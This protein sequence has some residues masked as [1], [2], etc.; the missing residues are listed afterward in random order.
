MLMCC[1]SLWN[2]LWK[3]SNVHLQLLVIEFLWVVQR[4]RTFCIDIHDSFHYA[5][6]FILLWILSSLNNNKQKR[7]HIYT[8]NCFRG[9]NMLLLVSSCFCMFIHTAHFFPN[10]F[11]VNNDEKMCTMVSIER[12][13]VEFLSAVNNIFSLVFRVFSMKTILLITLD[14]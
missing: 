10:S 7:T 12:A 11:S 8:L 3:R 9:K 2:V 1:G 14:C 13:S 5:L 4:T 6:H